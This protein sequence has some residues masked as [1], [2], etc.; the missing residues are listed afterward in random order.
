MEAAGFEKIALTR[1]LAKHPRVTSGV[2]PATI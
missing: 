1:D 2:R